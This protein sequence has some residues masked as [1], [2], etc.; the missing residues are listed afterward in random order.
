M[1][2]SFKWDNPEKTALVLE[3]NAP[4][5][6]REYEILSHEIQRA[7]DSVEHQVDLI[8]DLRNAGGIPKSIMYEL[9]DAYASLVDRIEQVFFNAVGASA[10]QLDFS[11]LKQQLND[12]YTSVK[13]FLLLP[14]H[15]VFLNRISLPTDDRVSWI[16]NVCYGLI[17]KPLNKIDD[18]EEELL[19]EK[20]MKKGCVPA[21]GGG[22]D[23]R[24]ARL[25]GDKAALK[26]GFRGKRPRSGSDKDKRC[27]GPL[28]LSARQLNARP[29]Q[30]S[31]NSTRG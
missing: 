9:R 3:F 25:P 13:S 23:N 14:H 26:I 18:I 11:S 8:I 2:V 4:W 1:G 6:W 19:D 17:N 22:A 31:A 15:K 21:N 27:L 16:E 30:L 24:T 20:I 29:T 7:F 28:H 12:R 10:N 5:Q